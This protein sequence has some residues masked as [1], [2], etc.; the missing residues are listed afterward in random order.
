[1]DNGWPLIL[2]GLRPK[3]RV[4]FILLRQTATKLQGSLKE[5]H[6]AT[7]LAILIG[8][9]IVIIYSLWT[10]VILQAQEWSKLLL[11]HLAAKYLAI[12]QIKRK[13]RL[14]I[15]VSSVRGV[16]IAKPIMYVSI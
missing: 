16:L 8:H 2:L 4:G 1:M 10:L 6:R 9:Q 12:A 5:L 13:N 14:I 3:R 15:I 11:L 7:M